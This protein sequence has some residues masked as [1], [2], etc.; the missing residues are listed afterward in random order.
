MNPWPAVP[1]WPWCRNADAGLSIIN[2]RKTNNAGL[3]FLSAVR[4]SCIHA[5]MHV[6]CPSP[7]RKSVLHVHVH[8]ACPCS[9]SMPILHAVFMSMLHS[10]LM[11]H[12]K[13]MLH[14]MSMLHSIS[15]LHSMSMFHVHV[16]VHVHICKNAGMPDCPASGQ[17][18]T[19]LKKKITMP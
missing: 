7:C 14:S 18:G 17:S 5:S 11:L 8:A 15:M 10:T 16:Y 6:Y 12:S 2:L 4:H 1:D 9:M 19:G 13:S 3:S